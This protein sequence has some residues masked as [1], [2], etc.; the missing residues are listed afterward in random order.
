MTRKYGPN[1]LVT[2]TPGVGKSTLCSRIASAA[3]AVHLNVADL[4]KHKQLHSGWD[5]DM[6]CSIYD[7][8]KLNDE[9]AR[10]GLQRGGFL[11]DFHS[12][13]G[14]DDDD[15]DHVVVLSADIKVL[16][17]RL[18]SRGYSD[19]K[20]DA[21]IE[22]EIFKVCLEDASYAYGKEKV[23]EL[24]HNDADDSAAAEEHILSLFGK[25]SVQ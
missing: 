13:E 3:G 14:I 9:L 20:I 11:V 7:E 2:G 1:I 18:K 25:C 5:D 23:V 24:L 16:A 17:Q 15:I 8:E 19:K 22:A 21:N 10:M 6:Q 4:V 12:V